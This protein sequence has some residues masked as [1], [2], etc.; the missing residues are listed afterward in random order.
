MMVITIKR[1]FSNS[2]KS[3]VIV[4]VDIVKGFVKFLADYA[5][6]VLTLLADCQVTTISIY[7]TNLSLFALE[8]WVSQFRWFLLRSLGYPLDH[9]LPFA[10]LICLLFKNLTLDPVINQLFI[11]LQ[12]LFKFLLLLE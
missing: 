1:Y 2:Q 6:V 10:C 11:L 7:Y 5:Y 8:A 12:S 4:L 3:F 9:S